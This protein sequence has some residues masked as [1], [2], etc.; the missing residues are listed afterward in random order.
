MPYS[1]LTAKLSLKNGSTETDIG[2]ISNWSIEEKRDV[3]EYSTLGSNTK[4]KKPSV[5]G[6]TASADGVADF[7]D[8]AQASLRTTMAGGSTVKVKF[9]LDSTTFLLGEAYI[10]SLKIDASASD[11]T[12]ISISLNG[13][14]TLLNAEA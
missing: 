6:W 12:K 1:G 5:Y 2:Y 13:I 10:D 4:G 14:G 11:F 7:T 9:Y 3:M 8:T